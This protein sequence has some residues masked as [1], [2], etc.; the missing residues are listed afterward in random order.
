MTVLVTGGAGYI[1]QHVVYALMAQG[2]RVVVL[3]TLERA[4]TKKMPP[5]VELVVGHVGDQAL[6]ERLVGAH[7]I[8]SV[9]HLAGYVDVEESVRCPGLYHNNNGAAAGVLFETAARAGVRHVVFSST[10]AVYG[11]PMEFPVGEGASLR[12]VS[13]YGKSK[14]F[15]EQALQAEAK[16]S[17]HLRFVI[18]RYFNVAGADPLGRCGYSVQGKPG[19]LIRRLVQ[20]SLRHQGRLHVFGTDYPTHDGTCVRDFVHVHD[21][22]HA[23]VCA[24]RY[25]RRRGQSQILNCGYGRGHSVLEAVAA[26]ERATSV[27]IPLQYSPRR[28]GD[29]SAVVADTSRI[30]RVLGWEPQFDTLEAM[31]GHEWDWVA[32]HAQGTP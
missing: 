13:P 16:R 6:V 23:H 22:A 32:R 9:L 28:A 10:A 8:E 27:R 31:I 12:P 29:T 21:I 30:R 7:G 5:G 26:A 2:E 24:L 17:R 19:H 20:V 4:S 3:D 14:V 11:N 18:L 15:A 1:G 25:L